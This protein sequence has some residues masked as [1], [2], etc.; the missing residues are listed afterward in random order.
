M[1]KFKAKKKKKRL[2][3]RLIIFVFFFVFSY[4]FMM[5]LLTNNK[6][7]F[8]FLK[9]DVNYVKYNVSKALTSKVNDVLTNPVNLLN[10]N[11]KNVSNVTSKNETKQTSNEKE[12]TELTVSNAEPIIYV[13][14]THQTESY[15]DYT[16]FDATYFL[17]EKLN[18]KGLS[19]YLEEQSMKVFLDNNGL[20]YYNSYVASRSYLDAARKNFSSL[21]YYFDIH[22]DS[23]S[24]DVSTVT[25]NGKNYAK[26]LF[27]VGTDN[28]NYEEN[29]KTTVALNEV[30]ESIVPGISRGVV[31]HGGTGFNG[32]YN[33]DVS[34]LV[35][36]IEVGGVDNTKEEVTNTVLVLASA[37]TKYVNE[38]L[39]YD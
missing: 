4:V 26:V 7:S 19:S 25:Y 34:S 11:I 21:K 16:V 20:K 31:Y 9:S 15:A 22:R 5:K 18:E 12:N 38:S 28:Q 17:S 23:V 29:A 36:L 30:I 32:V 24:K 37:I 39:V 1:K 6:L 13:Y 35:F 8:S 10:S 3:L 27:V 33:Q 2:R 14:N